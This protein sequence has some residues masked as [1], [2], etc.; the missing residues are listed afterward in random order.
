M[1]DHGAFSIVGPIICIAWSSNCEFAVIS[2][3]NGA[4]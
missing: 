2:C 4:S 3:Y 1:F